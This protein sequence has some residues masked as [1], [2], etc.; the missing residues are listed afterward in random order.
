MSEEGRGKRK[1]RSGVVVRSVSPKTVVVRVERTFRHPLYGKVV[2]DSKKYHAHDE[3]AHTLKEGDLVTLVESRPLSKL[4][5]WRVCR[6][7][8][9]S[10]GIRL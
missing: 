2:R 4:K 1:V 8:K 3:E 5:R 9:E 6:E 10:G 7:P